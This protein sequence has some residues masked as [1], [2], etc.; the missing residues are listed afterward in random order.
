MREKPGLLA[1]IVT[2]ALIGPPV[3]AVVYFG[4][5]M[6]V[7]AIRGETMPGSIGAV[8]EIVPYALVFGYILGI[9]PAL[10]AGLLVAV[11]I[12]RTSRVGLWLLAAP[13]AGA[14]ASWIGL[15]WIFLSP[16]ALTER[17]TVIA[18]IGVTGAVAALASI[19]VVIGMKTAEGA[20]SRP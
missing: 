19:L 7:A 15:F 14:L 4:V 3:G 1:T 8:L 17:L 2:H 10:A 6:S 16:A 13:V 5:M 20:D 18:A 11:T 9:L 12:R